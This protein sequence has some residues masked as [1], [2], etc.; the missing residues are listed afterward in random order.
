SWIF[1][2]AQ[3]LRFEI[4]MNHPLAV[5]VREG[6]RDLLHEPRDTRRFDRRLLLR[7]VEQVATGQVFDHEVKQAVGVLAP[8]ENRHD[9]GMTDAAGCARLESEPRDR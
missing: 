1:E 5:C 9:A 4:A 3:V 2:H 7:E 6:E 8:V